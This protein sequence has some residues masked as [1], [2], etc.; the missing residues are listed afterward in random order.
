[1]SQARAVAGVWLEGVARHGPHIHGPMA[2]F[3]P[4][5]FSLIQF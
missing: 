5:D 1:M 2:L 3:T 4:R